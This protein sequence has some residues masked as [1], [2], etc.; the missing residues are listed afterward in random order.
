M[1][2]KNHDKLKYYRYLILIMLAWLI[3]G[4]Y[5]LEGCASCQLLIGFQ[6][7]VVFMSWLILWF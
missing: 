4:V 7:M 2:H 6:A 3:F 5:W 1:K